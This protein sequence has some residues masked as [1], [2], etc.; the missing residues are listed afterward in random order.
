MISLWRRYAFK[1]ERVALT[2]LS[3]SEGSNSYSHPTCHS[4]M[5]CCEVPLKWFQS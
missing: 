5:S 1:H 3:R 2:T 4:L